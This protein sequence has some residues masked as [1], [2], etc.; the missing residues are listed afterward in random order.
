MVRF[1]YFYRCIAQQ[2][3]EEA[4]VNAV[5]VLPDVNLLTHYRVKFEGSRAR[6][7]HS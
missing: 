4:G 3:A 7:F 5:T 2:S 1:S 6:H